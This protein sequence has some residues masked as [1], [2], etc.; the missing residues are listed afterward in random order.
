[1][2]KRRKHWVIGPNV[3][4]SAGPKPNGK[5][6]GYLDRE[7]HQIFR[8]RNRQLLQLLRRERNARY[9]Y[10]I[11]NLSED[12]VM[13]TKNE[14]VTMERDV[15]AKKWWRAWW[16]DKLAD[17]VA[18]MA[19]KGDITLVQ[20][21]IKGLPNQKAEYEYIAVLVRPNWTA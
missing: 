18:E 13:P 10:F 12:R 16:I 2:R 8:E 7:A 21:R 11:G 9:T 19:D 5:S 1:M 17:R 14:A 20:R 4:Q 6:Y 3:N 15:Y